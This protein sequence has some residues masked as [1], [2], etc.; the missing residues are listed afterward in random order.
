[1]ETEVIRYNM[2][3]ALDKWAHI[4]LQHVNDEKY[5]LSAYN[6][7]DTILC[8]RRAPANT[9]KLGLRVAQ[10][11]DYSFKIIMIEQK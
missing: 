3:A 4:F 8:S 1:M 9:R 11:N 5:A 2:I 7:G 10:N 6:R